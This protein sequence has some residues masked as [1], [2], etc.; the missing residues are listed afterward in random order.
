MDI[1]VVNQL[2][3]KY[4]ALADHLDEK[5]RRLWAGVEARE[6]GHG[7]V[8]MVA[9][10]TGLSPDAIRRGVRE[11]ETGSAPEGRIRQ[12]GGGRKRLTEHDPGLL[13]ALKSLVEPATR[14]DPESPLRWTSKSTR[15]LAKELTD[16]GHR[17]SATSVRRLLQSMG[18]TLQRT[19]KTIEGR[20]HADRDDQ[21]NYIN[22]QVKVFQ[23]TGQPVISVDTKKKELIGEFANG[24]Q[25]WQPSGTPVPVNAHDFPSDAVGK[26]VPYGVYDLTRDEGW[27]SVGIS[28]DTAEFST[29]TILAWWENMGKEAYPD[30]TRLLITA[31]CGGSNGY[32]LRLWRTEL[33]ELANA[34]GLM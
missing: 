33:Q 13:E 19:R 14:G 7:G 6:L 5:A 29:N 15:K 32:R 27:V 3:R 12:P 10:A 34:T 16:R 30:A 1:T 2:R 4:T 31:D 9:E 21:F 23:S 8:T 22:E 24:G 20:N 11:V 18:F 28:K 17:V 26:A 25:E